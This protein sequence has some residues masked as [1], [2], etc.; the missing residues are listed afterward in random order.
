MDELKYTVIKTTNQYKRYCGLLK[1]M[2]SLPKHSKSI[3]DEIDLL[4]L[5]VEK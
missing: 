2:V 4:T 1:Q 3:Q 5:L